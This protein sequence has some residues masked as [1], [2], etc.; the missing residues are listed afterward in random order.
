MA[1]NCYYIKTNEIAHQK[2]IF[3]K[4]KRK[5]KEATTL[6]TESSNIKKGKKEGRDYTNNPN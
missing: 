5:Q 2:L 3:P 4:K 1:T 6:K